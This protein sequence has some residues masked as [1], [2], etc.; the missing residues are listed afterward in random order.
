MGG[1]H[2]ISV[3]PFNDSELEEALTRKGLQ[4]DDVPN[5]LKKMLQESS[6]FSEMPR[7]KR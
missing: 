4:L 6:L 7:T 2:K 3:D 1:C 5:S